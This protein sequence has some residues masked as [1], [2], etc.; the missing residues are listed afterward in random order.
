[1]FSSKVLS[2]FI[3]LQIFD[4][5]H[6]STVSSRC[7]ELFL[8]KYKNPACE[9]LLPH[10]G[11]NH[12]SAIVPQLPEILIPHQCTEQRTSIN[13]GKEIIG[14]V[15]VVSADVPEVHTVE[16]RQRHGGHAAGSTGNAALAVHFRRPDQLR[17]LHTPSCT[18]R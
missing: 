11:K 16:H 14:M 3:G 6:Y 8:K 17:L 7:Q 12:S 9:L 2:L 4:F 1:M 5:L 10:A 18:T 13:A 15:D